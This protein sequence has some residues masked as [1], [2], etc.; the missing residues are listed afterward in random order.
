MAFL[1]IVAAAI[2]S[3]A[4]EPGTTRRPNIVFFLVDDMGWQ[5]T[6]EPFHAEATAL[7]ARYRT[8]NLEKLADAGMKFSQA[9]ACSL[10]SPT[11]VSALT[12]LNAARHRVTNWTLRKN[13]S[14]DPAHDR[15]AMPR[16]NVNGVTME[17]G[18]DRALLVERTLPSQ[19]RDAGYRT[20]H[21]G[22]GHFGAQGTP[23]AD[24]R[25]LG[26]DVN[27]AGGFIGGP[28]S[29]HAENN[30]SADWRNEDRI[31]DVPG[32]EHYHGTDVNLTEALTREANAAIDRA[33]AE[34]KPFYLYMS[35]YAI[36]APWEK[37]AR[38]HEHYLAQGL[39][40]FDAIYASMIEAMDKSLGD[41]W[42][43]LRRNGVEDNTIFVFMS[44]NGAPKQADVNRP[45]RGHKL[46]PYEG[47]IRVPMIVRW[48]GETLPNSVCDVPVIVEDLY[49][50][51]LAL[52]GVEAQ[53]AAGDIIDGKSFVSVLQ[54][55]PDRRSARPLV[56]HYPH[57]Y[58]QYPY[59]V[60]REGDWK[61]IYFHAEQRYELYHL[62]KDLGEH[63]DRSS[64]R[65]KVRDRLAG[66][67]AEQLEGFGAQMPVETSSGLA[68]PYATHVQP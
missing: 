17:A 39:D 32:L 46:T 42:A 44:D 48:P 21:V 8:P 11:R 62:A 26:F 31:W 1:V 41:I 30:Y 49:P 37:D 47:G 22:K 34:S 2:P 38:F 63:R 64:D 57:V 12:G 68:V 52:A 16:W 61:L 55:A 4:E 25:H 29:Y 9:Y 7:N 65:P 5:D 23:G 27:I 54:G 67:L 59:S 56:W 53:P 6:S 24:P 20:I 58:D 13:A 19:L 33:V 36:H 14:P 10:C 50:T 3:I 35:H 28:G 15:F 43:N 45:L 60:I 40:S 18:V 66:L 51:L